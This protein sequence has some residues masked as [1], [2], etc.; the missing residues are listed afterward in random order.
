QAENLTHRFYDAIRRGA[1]FL[2][3]LFPN[4][5]YRLHTRQLE[6]DDR[7]HSS[8]I[9]ERYEQGDET[10]RVLWLKTWRNLPEQ[11][12]AH[13]EAHYERKI[14]DMITADRERNLARRAPKASLRLAEMYF[15]HHNLVAIQA[16]SDALAVHPDQTQAAPYSAYLKGLQAELGH[17]LENAMSAYEDVLNHASTEH[18]TTLLEHCLLRIASVSLTQGDPEQANQALDMASALNPGHW[19]LAAKLATLRHDDTHAVEAYAN[20]LTL[21]PGDHLR[22]LMLAELFN[23]LRS[24]EGIRQCMELANYCAPAEKAKL[25]NELGTLLHQLNQS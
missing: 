20:Y 25:L 15:S 22:I 2:R 9:L 6:L 17:E 10:E 19:P 14:S 13:A 7:T 3:T 8:E 23:R 11:A 12:A 1:Q 16:L 4:L 18:D 24:T 5:E 21:F